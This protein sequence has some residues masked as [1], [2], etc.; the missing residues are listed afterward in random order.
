[1]VSICAGNVTSCHAC[2]LRQHTLD[3]PPLRRASGVS[4]YPLHSLPVHMSCKFAKALQKGWVCESPSRASRS[5]HLVHCHVL[6][7]SSSMARPLSRT[8]VHTWV[9]KREGKATAG[10]SSGHF[11]V[12]AYLGTVQTNRVVSC[13]A[14]LSW[15]TEC[16]GSALLW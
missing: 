8:M 14:R 7:S 12:L 1:M 6:R 5:C 4:W 10:G 16:A 15:H 11:N 13:G 3:Q 2:A 9:G